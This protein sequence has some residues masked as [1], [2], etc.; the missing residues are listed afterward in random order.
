[1]AKHSLKLAIDAC[2]RYIPVKHSLVGA[3]TGT[4][5]KM[6]DLA[7]IIAV[8]NRGN[9]GCLKLLYNLPLLYRHSN[10]ADCSEVNTSSS[11]LA[12]KRH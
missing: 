9:N 2:L 5:K 6:C 7:R 3:G 10:E 8:F 12:Y 11:L 4:V 1:M